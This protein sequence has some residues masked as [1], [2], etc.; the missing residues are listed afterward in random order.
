MSGFSHWSCHCH[1]LLFFTC[2]DDFLSLSGYRHLLRH[3]HSSPSFA[4]RAD[5]T[6]RLIL[7]A[8]PLHCTRAAV[9]TLLNCADQSLCWMRNSVFS[10]PSYLL[11]S[12]VFL[13][14]VAVFADLA[15]YLAVDGLCLVL[16]ELSC[17]LT[18]C[19]VELLPLSYHILSQARRLEICNIEPA[20]CAAVCSR[21]S[22]LL[23]A[24]VESLQFSARS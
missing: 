9:P 4:L 2:S 19:C 18:Q 24:L 7:D 15:L 1:T 16:V 11:L 17:P 6:A 12:P 3:R 21:S 5:A 8:S 20:N 22:V 14:N 13:L 10:F 23:T